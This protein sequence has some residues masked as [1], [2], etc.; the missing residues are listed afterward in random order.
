MTSDGDALLNVDYPR[1]H[2]IDGIAME[3]WLQIAN[4]YVPQTSAQMQRRESLRELRSIDRMRQ[5]IGIP[6]SKY[7]SVTLESLDGGDHRIEQFETATN[8]LPSGKMDLGSSRIVDGNIGYLRISAMS[9]DGTE[10]VVSAMAAF[11]DTDGLVIDVRGNRGG[12]YQIL[13][14][15]YGYFLSDSDPPYVA[16]I[17]AYRLSPQ[18]AS[19]HLHDRPTFRLNYDGW[20]AA[21]RASIE[22]ALTD[23]EPVWAMPAEQFSDWHFM[24]LGRSSDTRQ[25]HYTKPVAVLSDAASF[26]ATDGFLSAFE[27]LPQVALIGG[28]SAGGSGASEKF[29]LPNSGIQIELSSMASFRPNGMTF[30]GNGIEVDI[31]VTATIDDFLGRSDTVL[32]RAMGWIRSQGRDD[33]GNQTERH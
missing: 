25:Y 32:E 23:F 2:S 19:D 4:R 20:S 11:R 9:T 28:P 7:V 16:N 8:R 3:R 14:A 24:V 17:A 12:F 13:H 10:A 27:N 33:I 18:F 21:E 15:L 31:A 30:D 22:K 26:S 1:V 5:E 29:F 6:E